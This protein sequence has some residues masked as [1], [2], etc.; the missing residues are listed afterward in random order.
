MGRVEIFESKMYQCE[1]ELLDVGPWNLIKLQH[2]AHMNWHNDEV[3]EASDLSSVTNS[4]L[5]PW[6]VKRNSL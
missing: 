4:F 1:G 6:L 3:V 5:G 2:T